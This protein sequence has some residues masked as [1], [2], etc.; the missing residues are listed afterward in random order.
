MK[1]QTYLR[2]L[3]LIIVFLFYACETEKV[4]TNVIESSSL[5]MKQMGEVYHFNAPIYDISSAPDGSIMV[6]LNDG[7]DR[8]IQIIK[9]GKVSKII[10]L[11][12]QTDIQG[13]STI[14]S[15]NAFITTGGTDLAM[16]GELYRISNGGTRMVAD[17]AA[18]ERNYD[19]DAMEGIQWKNQLCEAIDGFS[20]G[21]QNNPFKVTAVSGEEVLVA[22]AAGNSVL[23][24]KTTGEIDW[25][26]ILTPPL[27]NSGEFM[28]RWYAGES[29]DIQCYAQPVPTSI[30]IGPEGNV[31]VGELIGALSEADGV[32]PIGRSRVWKI[33]KDA[34]NVVLNE[35]VTSEDY[36][37]LIEG[38]TS[39]IDIE[40]GPD[41]LL[42][43]VEFDETSW[44]ASFIPNVASGGTITA[45]DLEGNLVMQ[46]A[47]GLEFP[48]AITFDK[49]GN[50]WLLQNNNTYWVTG[51]MP[52]VRKLQ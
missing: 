22:D 28:V 11:E 15:G 23:S 4:S 41:G 3:L 12:S 38:L 18:F 20:A 35:K 1:N 32:F 24:A 42:Y 8:S 14:G 16:N 39:V 36:E 45:Y 46:V 6:G 25:K 13:I 43:V 5:K 29:E 47:S 34:M 44:F 10:G 48:S 9:N 51:N 27:D 33:N 17:L 21:P 2:I 49:K 30:A 26:A 52:T 40:I 50:L 31:F 19:P 7:E 37:V